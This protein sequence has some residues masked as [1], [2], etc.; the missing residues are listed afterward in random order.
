MRFF[1][2][3]LC[4]SFV[5]ASCQ[6]KDD[7]SCIDTS[8]QTIELNS[9]TQ[10]GSNNEGTLCLLEVKDGRCPRNSECVW[11]GVATAKFSFVSGGVQH[12]LLLATKKF[13]N[14]PPTDTTV[15]G[16]TIKLLDVTPYPSIPATSVPASAT[17][18]ISR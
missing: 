3:L 4:A 2:T 15:A 7:L 14:F 17:V 12:Q 16:Y 18:Q 6:K 8:K 5:F 10:K 13:Y 11:E 9:C 1:S